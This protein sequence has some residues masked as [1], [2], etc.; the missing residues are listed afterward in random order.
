MSSQSECAFQ[1]NGLQN[2]SDLLPPPVEKLFS[3]LGRKRAL[4]IL[5]LLQKEK[6][7][8][9]DLVKKLGGVSP[10]T[11]SLLLSELHVEGLIKRKIFGKIPPL[12]S[13]YSLSNNGKNLLRVLEPLLSQDIN[14]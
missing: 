1:E 2:P 12:A 6:L 10:S 4:L 14:K 11:L 13:E 9:K 5:L 8:N 3:T 7:R